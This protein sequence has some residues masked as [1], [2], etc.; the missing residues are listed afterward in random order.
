RLS[1]SAEPCICLLARRLSLARTRFT[2]NWRAAASKQSALP[3][4]QSAAPP[5][6]CAS[7]F[8]FHFSGKTPRPM[9]LQ[10][11]E[12]RRL[13]RQIADQIRN[14]IGNGEVAPGARLP[15]ERDLARQLGV[16]RP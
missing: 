3:L 10:A 15:A 7:G 13:Y 8:S 16:S 2:Q 6:P 12:P 1:L 11:V 9:R 4:D 14:L 5:I